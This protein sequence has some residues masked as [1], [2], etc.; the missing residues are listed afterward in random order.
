MNKTYYKDIVKYYED[1][2]E[3][4]RKDLEARK[5]K[6]YAT[7]P[8]L[9]EIEAEMLKTSVD[10]AKSVLLNSKDSSAKLDLVQ[11]KIMDLKIERSELLASNKFPV[12]YLEP[13][14]HCK[15]CKDTGYVNNAKC[16][17]IK[18]KETEY[19][20]N[21]SNLS[22]RINNE[23]FD[24]FNFNYYT[25]SK[26]ENGISPRE[27]IKKIYTACINYVK[28]FK[29]H[30]NNIL[31][32]GNPGLG[33]TFLCNAIAQDL[34]GQG[35]QVIYQ[36][37]SDLIDQVRKSKFDFDNEKAAD[38]YLSELANCDLLI[39][40]DLGT[41]LSTQFSNLVIYDILNKRILNNKKMLISTNIDIDEFYKLYSERITSRLFGSFDTYEFLGE[42]IRLKMHKII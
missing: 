18:I 25:E 16:S 39:I 28:D 31:F 4:N 8:Q 36:T 2:Q 40:D 17:C 13:K 23:S 24:H 29:K 1:L 34:I 21:G 41:E 14:F 10:I 38:N 27:N 7:I 26:N 20:L 22:T 15:K 42:D 37:A 5:K 33:K 30:N 3:K 35:V 19:L 32:I 11:K 9:A 12:D 6:A